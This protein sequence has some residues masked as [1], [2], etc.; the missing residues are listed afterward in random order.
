MRHFHPF[1]FRHVGLLALMGFLL[2]GCGQLADP[3]QP[4]EKLHHGT[5]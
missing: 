2:A 5:A 4:T 3:G 1:D